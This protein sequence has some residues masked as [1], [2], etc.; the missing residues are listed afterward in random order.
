MPMTEVAFHFN[1]PDRTHYLCRLLRKVVGSGKR[2]LV[3]L[4]SERMA[5]V[6]HALWAFSQEDFIAHATTQDAAS[7]QQRSLVLLA[8]TVVDAG[9]AQVLINLRP[10]MPQ[11]FDVFE[12]VLELVGLE[13][14]ERLSARQRWRAYRQQGYA[15][16]QFDLAIPRTQAA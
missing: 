14:D 1:V 11:G 2:A 7:V 15:L 12:R 13:E 8:E 4:P 3:L 9:H 5:E 6:N 16:Q 10:D